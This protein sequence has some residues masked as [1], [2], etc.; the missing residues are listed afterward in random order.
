[1]KHIFPVSRVLGRRFRSFVAA[2]KI[3]VSD[4]NRSTIEAKYAV[5][6]KIPIRADQLRQELAN[7]EKLPFDNIV[8][9]NIGNPQQL[10]QAPLSWYRQTLSLLQ[11]PSL[12]DK[13]ELLDTDLR[14]K[15][16]PADVVSRASKLLASIGSVGAY[17]SSQGDPV[18]RESVAN[19]ITQRDGHAAHANDIFLTSGASASVSYLIQLLS[20]SEKSGFLIPIPQYP[21]YTASIALNNA[22]PIGYFLDEAND[23]STDPEQIRKLIADSKEDGIDVKSLVI[24]NPGNPTGAVLSESDITE[25][26][27]I[28][29]EHGLVII[30]DEVYQENLFEGKFVSVKKV[31]AKLLQQDPEAYK[32]VQLASLHSTS[33]GVSGEC[34]QRGGYMELVGF[35]QEVK[36][37]IFKLASINLCSV[38]TGQALIELMINP[39]K[40]GSP[41]YALYHTEVSAIHKSLQERATR[42]HQAFCAMTDVEC[43]KPQGAMYLFP[44]FN[45]NESTYPKLFE[46]CASTKS[47][48]DEFY[49]S[50]LLENTG[51]CC[52]PG[53]GFGQ[54]PGTYHVR[55][56][57]LPPGTEW[58]DRWEKF[59]KKFVSEY[60]S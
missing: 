42:L 26:I 3:G 40:P 60:K 35:S 1:M 32:N 47:T 27:N 23:W 48:V 55:T 17:S 19:F 39:P 25:L 24:I 9:A 21:L 11:Y 44:R 20:R 7:N 31:L 13:L 14:E 22:T 2:P 49:C 29:A 36:D 37:V 51:I 8:S 50:E 10:D 16:Y 6:G 52:V 33:K 30:A 59:H 15:L 12:I 56:T 57:F 54:V 38:V 41:S 58:I 34:G 46:S 28:S 18:V 43:N 53:S 4:L 5:R 45:F